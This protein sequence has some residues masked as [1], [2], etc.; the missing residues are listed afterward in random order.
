MLSQVV[1]LSHSVG[2]TSQTLRP[3]P[4]TIATELTNIFCFLTDLAGLSD[5]LPSCLRLCTPNRLQYGVQVLLLPV[6]KT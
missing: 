5:T 3:V 6:E 2:V 1:M 4:S